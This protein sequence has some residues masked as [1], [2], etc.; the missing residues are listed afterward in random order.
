MRNIKSLVAAIA[1]VSTLVGTNTAHAG[2]NI[3]PGVGISTCAAVYG[4]LA[5]FADPGDRPVLKQRALQLLNAAGSYDPQ[6]AAASVGLLQ[7]NVARVLANDPTIGLEIR[8]TEAG[9]RKYLP[10][11]G[12]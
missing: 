7:Q 2:S 12:L 5:R 9:C 6:A 1:I 11:W 10:Q 8:S 3:P 4:T